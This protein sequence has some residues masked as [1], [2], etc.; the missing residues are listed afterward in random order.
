MR[1]QGGIKEEPRRNQRGAKK[2][3]CFK[4]NPMF[5]QSSLHF[6]FCH[7]AKIFKPT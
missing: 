4:F 6:K 5:M 7:S 2:E 3:F 1:S